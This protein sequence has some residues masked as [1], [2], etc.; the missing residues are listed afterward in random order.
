MTVE[1]DVSLTGCFRFSLFLHKT[2]FVLM[3]SLGLVCS[4]ADRA[5]QKC[6]CL[7]F[8]KKTCVDAEFVTAEVFSSVKRSTQ[9]F[10]PD[11]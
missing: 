2:R 4:H 9:L 5:T 7:V 6:K 3:S 1:K 10:K 8:P 11:I